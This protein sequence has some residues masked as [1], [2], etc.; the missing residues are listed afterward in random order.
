[1]YSTF[2]CTDTLRL[3]RQLIARAPFE[4]C[5]TGDRQSRWE[6]NTWNTITD[7]PGHTEHNSNTCKTRLQQNNDTQ[8][9]IL[10][11]KHL[12]FNMEHWA[13]CN[14]TTTGLLKH[15]SRDMTGNRDTG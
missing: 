4:L 14:K 11:L 12:G 8:G 13:H 9:T 3:A 5:Y 1:M 7:T 2:F 15:E 10:Q 6:W